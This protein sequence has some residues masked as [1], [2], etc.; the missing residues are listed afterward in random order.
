MMHFE[1]S[2]D[3][4]DVLIDS[5]AAISG[6]YTGSEYTARFGH[7]VED[8]HIHCQAVRDSLLNEY[9]PQF[10]KFVNKFI[11]SGKKADKT[12][13]RRIGEK[14]LSLKNDVNVRNIMETILI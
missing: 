7:K 6:R 13:A 5:A 9:R 10:E 14:I 2:L 12:E 1:D 11:V 3:M 8:A 4:A